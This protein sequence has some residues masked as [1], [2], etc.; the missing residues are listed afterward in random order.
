MIGENATFGEE[1]GLHTVLVVPLSAII[2]IS[3]Q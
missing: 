3:L 1:M 2:A